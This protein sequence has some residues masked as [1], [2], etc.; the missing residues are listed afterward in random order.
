MVLLLL[1]AVGATL[2][3]I[4]IYRFKTALLRKEENQRSGE[5]MTEFREYDTVEE[6]E[7]IEVKRND[8]YGDVEAR[9]VKMM[10]NEAYAQID[11]LVTEEPEYAQPR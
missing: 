6:M 7:V 9:G 3:A 5:E 11:N 10:R 1:L 4:C 8:A 2:S